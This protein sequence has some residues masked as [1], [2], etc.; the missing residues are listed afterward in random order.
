MRL[1]IVGISSRAAGEELCVT[2]ELVGEGER[3]IQ[4]ESFVISARQYLVLCPQ[5]GESNPQIYDAISHAANVFS[6]VKRGMA[7]LGYGACS[8]NA[9]LLKLRGKGFEREVAEDAVAQLVSQGLLNAN[10]DACREAEKQAAKLW[11]KKR[12][13]AELYAKGYSAESVGAAMSALADSGV[14]YIQACR[15]LI[16]KKYGEL[17][18]EST[19]RRKAIAALVRYGYTAQEIKEALT[20]K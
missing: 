17:P 13:A 15:T 3:Q 11:G 18:T 10:A 4:R 16:E 6:A 8:Q 20:N 9:L 5:K 7:M 19:A 14:D 2:F 12:I 1:Y